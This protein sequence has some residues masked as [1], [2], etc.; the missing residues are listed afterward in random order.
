MSRY[1]TGEHQSRGEPP[2]TA[3]QIEQAALQHAQNLHRVE[4]AYTAIGEL[5]FSLDHEDT[6]EE[7]D[8]AVDIEDRIDRLRSMLR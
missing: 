3:D 5:V 6:T 8:K 1:G 7:Y 4:K 2:L